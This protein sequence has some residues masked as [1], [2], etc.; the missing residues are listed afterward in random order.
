MDAK[1]LELE[2]ECRNCH[3]EGIVDCEL[4]AVCQGERTVLT[5][6]GER[7]ADLIDRRISARLRRI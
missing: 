6:F 4:C 5:D 3:G 1:D 2:K 7:V